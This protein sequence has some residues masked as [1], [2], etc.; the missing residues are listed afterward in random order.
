MFLLDKL[1][2]AIYHFFGKLTYEEKQDKIDER[3]TGTYNKYKDQELTRKEIEKK[4]DDESTEDEKSY[5]ENKD[6]DSHYFDK[7]K[8]LI[9]Q[10]IDN[11]EEKAK[12]KKKEEEVRYI[13]RSYE[14]PE[15]IR[16]RQQNAIEESN[17][18]EASKELPGFLEK[19]KSDFSEK[20]NEKISKSAEIIEKEI[21]N[22]SP[23]NLKIFLQNLTENEKLIDKLIE[24]S[25]KESEKILNKSYNNP[26]HFN[27]LLIGKTGVGK[28]TLINGIFDFNEN[29]GAK[30]GVGKPITQAFD[31]FMSDKRKGLKIIDSKGIEMGEHN[32]NSV[33]Q[34]SKELIEK[35]GGE[36]ELGKLIHCIWYCFQS[37]YLRFEPIEKETVSLLM[38]QYT[39]NNLP[40]IIVI[41]QNYDDE[42]TKTMTEFIKDEFKFLNREMTIMPVIA[43]KKIVMKKNNQIVYEKEGIEELIQIS[44]EKSQKAISPAIKKSIEEQIIQIFKN[45]IE[46][47]KNKLKDEL[48]ENIQKILNEITEDEKMENNIS[49]FSLII[50][51]TLNI[52]FQIS[53]ISEKSKNDINIFLDNLCKWGIERLNDI[54]SD[55]V[56]ENSNELG[57]L[58]INEQT[59]VKN[60][61][62]CQKTLSNEKTVDQ[63]I[64]E[65]ENYL[66]PSIN[67][68]VYFLAIK[69]I[70]KIISEKI[71]EISEEIIKEQFNKIIPEIRKNICDEKLKQISNKVLQNIIKNK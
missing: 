9:D 63:Y 10:Y 22:Y 66:K 2:Q 45:Q 15:S 13:Y 30:T 40:I 67:N 27:V 33:F 62:N 57:L 51:K 1:K 34:L 59:K 32:I 3:L 42:A 36:G 69:D 14:S 61:H 60:N 50:E 70:Y 20:L 56:K 18:A 16:I 25:K 68:K 46:N 6:L 23:A 38:N 24:D 54:I 12:E 37:S 7:R 41:T 71:V 29:E 49:H 17:R 58:L 43:K 39:D 8:I 19:I 4:F 47:N 28:S 11:K 65:S 48:K 52:F 35:R 44:F 64:I 5:R 31:E 53:N 26:S 21:N 55:L